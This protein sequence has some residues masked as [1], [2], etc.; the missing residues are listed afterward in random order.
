MLTMRQLLNISLLLIYVLSSAGL[1]YS[2]HFCGDE[3]KDIN[4]AAEST[5]CCAAEE[6]EED[7]C[8]DVLSSE[9]H[10][11]DHQSKQLQD[12]QFDRLQLQALPA[13]IYSLA[14]LYQQEQHERYANYDWQHPSPPFPLY[15]KNQVFLI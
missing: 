11:S 15:L 12:F 13:S 8:E 7:C 1:T 6:G 10:A 2:M 9:I 3:L 4:W 14:A 5:S